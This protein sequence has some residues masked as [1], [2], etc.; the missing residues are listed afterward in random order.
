MQIF[1]TEYTRYLAY[2]Y[3]LKKSFI[4]RTTPAWKSL[5]SLVVSS[6]TSEVLKKLKVSNDDLRL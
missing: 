4:P 3:T 2:S 6:K 1:V 5:P